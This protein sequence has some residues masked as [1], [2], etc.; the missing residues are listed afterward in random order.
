[1]GC[2]SRRGGFG[3]DVPCAGQGRSRLSGS[4]TDL[5]ASFTFRLLCHARESK[6]KLRPYIAHRNRAGSRYQLDVSYL[7]SSSSLAR[8]A[9]DKSGLMLM[10]RC[11]SSL[12]S[13]SIA[14]S[15]E[16]L[17]SSSTPSSTAPA[18]LFN[19]KIAVRARVKSEEPT[20]AMTHMKLTSFTSSVTSHFDG[21]QPLS[22]WPG[23]S[24]QLCRGGAQLRAACL[25]RLS[26][27]PARGLRAPQWSRTALAQ[28]TGAG[29]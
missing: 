25:V 17:S 22:V 7:R 4:A 26:C 21:L 8:L 11:S 10:S 1:M 19:K 29:Q 9:G 28:Y 3:F 23:A 24:S 2:G 18:L 14:S 6:H 27:C 15:V 20:H 13:E 12:Q 5:K 16:S